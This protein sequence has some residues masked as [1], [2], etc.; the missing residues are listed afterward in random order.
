MKVWQICLTVVGLGLLLMLVSCS[1]DV[2]SDNT[3]GFLSGLNT[4]FAEAAMN[5]SSQIIGDFSAKNPP[6]PGLPELPGLGSYASMLGTDLGEGNLRALREPYDID[7][8][9]GTWRYDTLSEKWDFVSPG[10]PANAILLEW[11]Y[12][13]TNEVA[14]D[15]AMRFDSLEFYQDSL[16]TDV[17]VGVGIKIDDDVTWL[18]WLKLE[19]EYTSFEEASEVSLIYEI[20]GYLQVGVSVSTPIEMD[21]TFDIDSTDFDGT[22]HLWVIDKTSNNYRVDLTI[23]VNDGESGNLVLED[24]DGWKMD[25]DVSEDISSETGYE[26]RTISGEITKDG[27]HAADIDGTIWDPDDDEHSS[28]I[29]IVFSDDTEGDLEDY[30]A[31]ISLIEGL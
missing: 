23:T 10:N 12:L 29:T 2:S 21:T 8:L 31:A 7:T 20:V 28:E 15:A 26:E 13:D 4:M 19:V 11:V 18:A 16:P 1:K 6:T 25:L 3:K 14:H 22:V 24:S 17:W 30:F 5:E 9:Y 27:D